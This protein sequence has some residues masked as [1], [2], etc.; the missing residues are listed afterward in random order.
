LQHDPDSGLASFAWC[1]VLS[2][3]LSIGIQSIQTAV[4]RGG[5]LDDRTFVSWSKD[6][7][8]GADELVLLDSDSDGGLDGQ[9]KVVVEFSAK[10]PNWFRTLGAF[11]PEA[12]LT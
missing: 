6:V 3:C 4:S 9:G 10:T 1:S 5:P 11:V 7:T 8:R 12:F 2:V